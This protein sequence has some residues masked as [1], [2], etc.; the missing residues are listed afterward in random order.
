MADPPRY[1]AGRC[2]PSTPSISK[3]IATPIGTASTANELFRSGFF[4]RSLD[5]A[6][7]SL[8]L[9]ADKGGPEPGTNHHHFLRYVLRS[10]KQA[11]AALLVIGGFAMVNR[12]RCR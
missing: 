6:D 5:K 7:R 8:A 9:V 10:L 4:N 1:D 12:W 2:S 11:T 3:A